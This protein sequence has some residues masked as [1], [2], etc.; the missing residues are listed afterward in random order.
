[1]KISQSL[2][3][4]ANIIPSLKLATKKDKGGVEGTGS[5]KVKILEDKVV[6][7]KD[8]NRNMIH[9]VRYTLEENG[10]KKKY[11]T[12][13]K[14]DNG[15]LSYLVQKLAE[16]PEGTE[17]VLEYVQKGLRGFIDVRQAE[18]KEEP[19]IGEEPVFDTDGN[20]IT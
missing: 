4:K 13:V 12:A 11:D 18:G 10:V 15:E 16:I 3:Q 1:M 8:F 6:E 20:V 17:I 19:V 2:V 7:G 9:M 5:H 14:G